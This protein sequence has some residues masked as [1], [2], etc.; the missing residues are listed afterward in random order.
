MV[1]LMVADDG[2]G[3]P[4][5]FDPERDGELGMELMINLSRQL[6]GRL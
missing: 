5:N 6:G 2:V 3:L 1:H 4:Q